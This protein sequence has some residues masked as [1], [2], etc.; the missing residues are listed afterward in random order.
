MTDAA[1]LAEV[2]D[3]L[4][5]CDLPAISSVQTL[6]D[7]NGDSDNALS[8]A[9]SSP[10]SDSAQRS[11]SRNKSHV[12]NDIDPATKREMEKAKD[13]KRRT[14]YRERRR[15]ERESLLQQVAALSTELT[16]LEE[17]QAEKNK[18]AMSTWKVIAEKQLRER[19]SAEAYHRR[20]IA[21]VESRGAMIHEFQTFVRSRITNRE[22]ET[23]DV[24]EEEPYKH[25]KVRHEPS[26][27][28]LYASY[29][30]QLD[31]IYARTDEVLQ[32]CGLDATEPNS[33]VSERKWIQDG[34]TGYYQFVNLRVIPFAFK[35]AC[36]FAWMVGQMAHRK[37][38]RQVFDRLKDPEN[39]AAFKFR[40]TS[41]L[42]TGKV[43]SVLQ[44]SVS[45]RYHEENRHVIVWRSFTEGEG[46]F[47]GM[48][49]EESGHCIATPLND[50]SEVGTV[51][52]TC[53][54]HVPMHFKQAAD[55]ELSVKQFT[56]MM[57]DSCAEDSTEIKNRLQKLLLGDV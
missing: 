49:A 43:V 47:A 50:P 30:R 6:D 25:K 55:C 2:E 33:N 38:D 42:K 27:A 56:G 17:A 52:T 39:S 37:E 12:I 48:H 31:A 3:F 29:F 15:V 44:R 14:T 21:A 19:L 40:V 16:T 13:R 22:K 53:M 24:V 26:E 7:N 28:A 23:E 35:K 18:L 36:R 54:R 8:S 45:R 57:L 4:T 10:P 11:R 32:V 34:D 20:L 46:M 9:V 5:L 1:F 51:L 41:R